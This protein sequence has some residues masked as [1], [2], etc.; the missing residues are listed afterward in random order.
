MKQ[1]FEAQFS[2]ANAE[3]FNETPMINATIEAIQV[4]R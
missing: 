1:E 3:D 4:D 2:E